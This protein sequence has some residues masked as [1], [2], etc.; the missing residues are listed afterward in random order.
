MTDMI[1]SSFVLLITYRHG[2]RRKHSLQLLL[3][4]S[5][6]VETYLFA[7]PLHSNGYTCHNMFEAET[8]RQ[9]EYAV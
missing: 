8:F 5:V 7:Q 1:D 2:P 3:Y 4:L 9:S 6:A